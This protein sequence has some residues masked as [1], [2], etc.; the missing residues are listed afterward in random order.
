MSMELKTRAV[1]REFLHMFP[2][3]DDR[4]LGQLLGTGEQRAVQ[5][6]HI[7]LDASLA[8]GS[9]PY[10]SHDGRPTTQML[11]LAG[12]IGSGLGTGYFDLQRALIHV[13]RSTEGTVGRSGRS[14]VTFATK[15]RHTDTY[16]LSVEEAER[17]WG[18]LARAWHNDGLHHGFFGLMVR[19]VGDEESA[20]GQHVQQLRLDSISWPE[21]GSTPEYV[22]EM[23]QYREKMLRDRAEDRGESQDVV[24]R[25]PLTHDLSAYLRAQEAE[26]PLQTVQLS[27]ERQRLA[28]GEFE[29]P[30]IRVIVAQADPLDHTPMA[31]IEFQPTQPP[32]GM[33]SLD[34][35]PLRFTIPTLTRSS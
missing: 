15:F 32:R 19:Y 12:K 13:T 34:P 29:T 28:F 11:L 22:A 1:V 24:S 23:A 6:L 10:F 9:S 35:S 4:T 14:A 30:H 2:G 31:H 16:G 25:V 17:R 33:S 5:N 7:P 20:G 3:L 26:I 8:L 18:S 27:T 21:H